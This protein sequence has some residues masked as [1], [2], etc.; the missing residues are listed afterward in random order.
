MSSNG[1]NDLKGKKLWSV[2]IADDESA[3]RALLRER[4]TKHGYSVIAEAENG[5]E[6]VVLYDQ[7]KPDVLF[8][9]IGMPKGNGL[10]ILPL[11]KEIDPNARIIMITADTMPDT[12][13][14]AVRLGALDY[15]AK[16]SDEK[17]I[18]EALHDALN[19]EPQDSSESSKESSEGVHVGL[20]QLRNLTQKEE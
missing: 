18:L 19:P 20:N 5:L 1:I 15:V 13:K 16:S 6:A 9:D 2:I 4:I 11:L 10:T 12:V 3:F 17:R 7:Y 8:L 14:E